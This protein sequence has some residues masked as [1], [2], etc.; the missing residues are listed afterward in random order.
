[1]SLLRRILDSLSSGP[2]TPPPRGVRE[3]RAASGHGRAPLLVR[4]NTQR[5]FE[6]RG[7]R[8]NGTALDGYYR[9]KYGSFRGWITGATG[10]SP[11][12]YIVDP[13]RAVLDG[14]HGACFQPR[15]RREF[16]VHWRTRPDNVDTG[17]LR[18][19]HTILEALS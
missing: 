15:G 18:I 13:P 3:S 4:R 12:F 5:L 9:T 7:W 2:P 6:E 14:P 1:M 16:R 17:I 11:A 19:E 10:S 8:L